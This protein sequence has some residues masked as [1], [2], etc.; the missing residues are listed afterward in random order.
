MNNSTDEQFETNDEFPPPPHRFSRPLVIICVVLLI[1]FIG[2]GSLMAVH[3]FERSN[4]SPTPTPF[5]QINSSSNGSWM[6]SGMI[7]NDA[8]QRIMQNQIA[9]VL[10]YRQKDAGPANPP[11]NSVIDIEVLP[12]GIP[13]QGDPSQSAQLSLLSIYTFYPDSTCYPRLLA[14]VKKINKTL[15]K[16][17]QVQVGWDYPYSS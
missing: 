3:V 4:V 5:P 11:V 17:N 6:Q 2:L 12:R 8:V 13:F 10:I 9:F 1:I 14:E 15:P 7:C 16:S